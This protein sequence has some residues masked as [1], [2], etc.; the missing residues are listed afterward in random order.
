MENLVSFIRGTTVDN[1]EN[2]LYNMS[3]EKNKDWEM[4]FSSDMIESICKEHSYPCYR[5]AH[6][7]EGHVYWR[8]R[9]KNLTLE[10]AV[11][12]I[13]KKSD[14]NAYV[15]QFSCNGQLLYKKPDDS[16]GRIHVL[17]PNYDA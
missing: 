10:Y 16:A 12:P 11:L 1:F 7:L 15:L 3:L 6:N 17:W 14:Y 5:F 8:M 13:V 9:M 2:V 4:F